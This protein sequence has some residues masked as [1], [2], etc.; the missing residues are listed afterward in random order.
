MRHK[1]I[2]SLVCYSLLSLPVQAAGIMDIYLLAQQ[3]DPVLQAAWQEKLAGE[4]NEMLGRSGLLPSLS[5]SWQSGLKNWQT[6]QSRQSKG[7]FSRETHMVTSHRQYQS[8]SG[9]LMLTQPLFD[10]SAWSRYQMGIAQKLMADAGWRA[11]FSELAVRVVNSYLDLMAAQDKVTLV[12]EQLTA[13][14]QQLKQNQHMLR[15]GEGT[16]TEVAE[17]ESH[18]ALSETEQIAAQDE[19][20]D[21]QRALESLIGQ[22]I[23]SFSQLDTL[24]PGAFKPVALIPAHLEQWQQMALRDNAELAA[25]QQQIQVNHYQTEQQRA[26]FF[27]QIQLYASH[28]LNHSSSDSTIDQRYETSSVGIQLNY[29]LYTGGYSS[30]AVRQASASYNKSKYDLEH[31]TWNILNSLHKFFNQCRNVESRLAAYQKAVQS[32]VLQVKAIQQG[33]LAGQRSNIDLLNAERQLYK[34]RLDLTEEKYRYIRAWVML[35]HHS[36]Q[37]TPDKVAEVAHY[38]SRK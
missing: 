2:A 6:S 37:L 32:A 13:Y 10:Y 22:P 30:A 15:T 17:T 26:G 38:F 23:A 14:R 7:L 25:S 9:T 19:Q 11:K 29:A 5:L 12:N 35:L 28:G 1:I 3:K 34:S 8:H 33:I 18:L 20:A 36:G 4:E 27:P 16:V 24:S 21:A 31:S